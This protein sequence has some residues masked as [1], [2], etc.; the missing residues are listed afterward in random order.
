MS[1]RYTAELQKTT[2]ALDE[3]RQVFD[4]WEPGM[5][6]VALRDRVTSSG[7]LGRSSTTRTGDIVNRAFPQRF[8]TPD[9]R[10]ARRVKAGLAAGIAHAEFRDLVFLYTMRAYAPIRD[11]LAERYWPAVFSGHQQIDGREIVGFLQDQAGTER[12][13]QGW[14]ENVTARVARNLGKTLTDFGF[15]ED[16]RSSVR[17]I[18]FWRPSDFL[19]TYVVI[20][21][22]QDGTP[23]SAII[24]AGE[25]EVFGLD[26]AARLERIQRLAGTNGPFLFQYS[27]EIAQFTWRCATVEEWFDDPA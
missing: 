9:D 18:R 10:A 27:G 15:F 6:R 16:R 21:A 26:M 17:R 11:F 13:P 22:H 20:E 23:D 14:S 1:V 2:G 7:A 5:G 25:W 3:L 4:L 12:N 8:L 19:V 24:T